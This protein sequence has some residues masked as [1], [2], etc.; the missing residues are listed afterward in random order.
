[1]SGVGFGYGLSM[2]RS[3]ARSR[4]L[5]RRPIS[6]SACLA[7]GAVARSYR[8]AAA[9]SAS[10]APAIR[11]MAAGVPARLRGRV[12]QHDRG[13]L[14]CGRSKLPPS[15]WQSLWCS[16]VP[17]TRRPDTR[18]AGRCS[19]NMLQVAGVAEAAGLDQLGARDLHAVQLAV[20]GRFLV[21]EEAA[22]P[23]ISAFR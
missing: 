18:N 12:G 21:V 17:A 11:A 5:S 14:G 2:A 6:E 8:P 20:V 10:R 1:V 22:A 3:A 4:S 16:A 19:V 9:S 23:V 13:Y 15:T 7:P